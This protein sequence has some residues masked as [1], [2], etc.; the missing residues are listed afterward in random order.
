[1]SNTPIASMASGRLRIIVLGYVVR[2]PLGGMVWSNLQYLMGLARLGHDVYFLEDSDDY[3]SCY[4]PAKG[5]TDTDPTYGLRFAGRVFDKIGFGEHWA[6][7]DAHLSRWFGPSA[8]RTTEICRTADLLFNLCGV[9]PMRPWLLQVP[10]R[11]L[12]DEDPVFTQIKFLTDASARNFA[13]QHTGFFSF[14]ENIANPRCEIPNDGFPWQDTRQPVVLEVLPVTT[15]PIEGRF[16]TVMQWTS[17]PARE[18]NGRR[19]GMKSDSFGPYLSLPANVGRI[20]ELAVGGQAAD[21]LLRSNG[22]CIRDPLE[23]TRDPWTYQR[24]IQE[25]KAEFS[26]AKHGYVVTRSG[27]FSERSVAYL[28]SGRPV[29]VQETG[30]SDWLLTGAGVL[31]FAT[32]EEARFGIED[33]VSRYD[34]HCKAA[35]ILAE[36]Y[37]DARKVL[38]HL[39]ERALF[40]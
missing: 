10:H 8:D 9:N 20:F 31:P 1:M 39:I 38:P 3:P 12:I 25:S 28:A 26:V 29:V 34:F 37:F 17:Y 7:Y 2:G 21:A 22:W 32:P 27:W 13:A 36:E 18:H 16:T 6:Y 35:R 14:A 4:D 24:F 19:Y 40:P 5:Y 23:V 11:V 15:G 30:F 33:I